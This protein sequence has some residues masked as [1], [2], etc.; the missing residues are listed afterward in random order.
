M[1]SPRVLM[2]LSGP[3]ALL[4]ANV[5]GAAGFAAV[6]S[7]PRFEVAT[8]SGVTLREVF[9]ITNGASG[10]ITYHLKTADFSLGDDYGVSFQDALAPNSCRPWVA[11][12][13]PAVP[14]SP[15]AT[16]RY[17]FEVRVPADAPQGECRFAI[18][19]EGDEP[20]VAQ[21]G[22]VRVP[23]TGRIAV[24]VYARIGAAKAAIDVFGPSS[25]VLNGQRLPTLRVHNS[26]DAH[27]RMGGFLTGTDAK[28]I[29]YDFIPSTLP[30]LPGEVRPVYLSPSLAGND[31]PQLT[32]PVTV[33]GKL[34]WDDQSTELNERF[35]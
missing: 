12:E 33:Q 10:A 27:T 26:G 17:R 1:M 22:A 8:R 29:K 18:M 7:P 19:I 34:E 4:L 32:F 25:A 31:H 35:E 11:L 16:V 3:A 14:L 2:L 24:I 28:G 5:A 30:I 15:G 6:V 13:R 23:I 21:A 20:Y 9:S